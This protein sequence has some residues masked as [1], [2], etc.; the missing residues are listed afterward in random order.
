VLAWTVNDAAEVERL[1]S[2]GVD[3]IVSDDPGMALRSLAT[4]SAP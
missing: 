2:L 3:G 4:L 1:A